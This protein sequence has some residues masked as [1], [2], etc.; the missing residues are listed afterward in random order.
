MS[1]EYKDSEDGIRHITLSGRLDSAGADVIATPFAAVSAASQRR[2]VLDLSAV[3]FLASIGIRLVVQNAKALHARG[4]RMVLFVG[5]NEQ[6]KNT[7]ESTGI[8]SII[9][10]FTDIGQAQQAALG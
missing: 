7:I 5:Q 6:V 3:N 10:M 4:G 9:P 1:I 8:A 2:V